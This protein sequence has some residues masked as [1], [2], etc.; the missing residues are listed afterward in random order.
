MPQ[1]TV[2]RQLDE[3]KAYLLILE[4]LQLE[5]LH[6]IY[7]TSKGL[8]KY[9]LKIVKGSWHP[10]AIFLYLIPGHQYLPERRLSISI[11]D[12]LPLV[13]SGAYFQRFY[14]TVT[15]GETVLKCLP[16]QATVQKQQ[17]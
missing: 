9:S 14:T 3:K 17:A 10:Y 2:Q 4:K 15:N 12:C 6:L 1:D 8:L 7:Y 5:V 13:A 16:P 11:F